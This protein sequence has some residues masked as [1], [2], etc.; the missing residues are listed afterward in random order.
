[1]GSS[2]IRIIKII[3]TTGP[4]GLTGS[5]G[6][7]GATGTGSGKTGPTGATAVYIQSISY[8]N[9]DNPIL[10]ASDGTRYTIS[11]L[12]GPTGTTGNVI[13]VTLGNKYDIL[14]S[15][16]GGTLN[17]YGLSFT[18]VLSSS[19]SNGTIVVTPTDQSAD[20]TISGD[21][22]TS[23]LIYAKNT[24]EISSTRIDALFNELSF[25]S[26]GVSHTSTFLDSS[27]NVGQ[28]PSIPQ[29]N[30]SAY[31]NGY[32]QVS[33]YISGIDPERGIYIDATKASI[34]T[35]ETP[36]GIAGFSLNNAIYETG[37]IVSITLFISGSELWS[38]PSN[39]YFEDKPESTYF[40]C[41]INIMNM[42]SNNKGASW[43]ATVS[44]RGY[45]VTG[46][47]DYDML[48]SCCYNDDEGNFECD[49]Y[50]T[51]G[52]CNR[53][54]GTF[55]PATTCAESCGITL[56]S[57]CCSE[58]R[59]VE[60]ISEDECELFGG[61]F[62]VSNILSCD[63]SLGGNNMQRLCYDKCQDPVVCCK[64]GVCLGEMT[65]PICEEI[66]GGRAVQ[67]TCE[68]V[69]C[70]KEIPFYGACCKTNSCREDYI[71]N[72]KIENDEVFMGHGTQ[73]VNSTTC[74]QAEQPYEGICCYYYGGCI[75]TDRLTCESSG[76]SFHEGQTDCQI[77]RWCIEG[78]P[79]C[80][81][82]PPCPDGSDNSV[83]PCNNTCPDG[84][85]IRPSWPPCP[86][87]P[88]YECVLPIWSLERVC[89]QCPDGAACSL[90]ECPENC[91][92]DIIVTP[93]GGV[94]P[95][96]TIPPGGGFGGGG[97]PPPGG[98]GQPPG[99]GG[100]PPSQCPTTC[101]GCICPK[102]PINGWMFDG[103]PVPIIDPT[104]S[105]TEC[106]CMI[107]RR[108]PKVDEIMGQSECLTPEELGWQNLDND[109]YGSPPDKIRACCYGLP[110]QGPL[111][112]AVRCNPRAC[113]CNAA[114]REQLGLPNEWDGIACC[115]KAPCDGEASSPC[116][117]C[118]PILRV[119]A[120]PSQPGSTTNVCVY[121][122]LCKPKAQDPNKTNEEEI[123]AGI[124]PCASTPSG[125]LCIQE[126]SAC[127]DPEPILGIDCR[128]GPSGVNTC[129]YNEFDWGSSTLVPDFSWLIDPNTGICN[130]YWCGSY[131]SPCF[132]S[133]YLPCSGES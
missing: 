81:V 104:T 48:G 115:D 16:V 38:F 32:S 37:D 26:P 61:K 87:P 52:F 31:I 63:T 60:N 11:G 17:L 65:K 39:V 13:G 64:N 35:I 46:C 9:N 90:S 84:S 47:D 42:T 2:A 79:R 85:P 130:L 44:D 102:F 25:A 40:G 132:D 50:R 88:S 124:C 69:D 86:G 98:G 54:N 18:G 4:T 101:E 127:G 129:E 66:F 8:D 118:I 82:Q 72:C 111:S 126:A 119:K 45:G 70:C 108:D 74:C 133:T 58:G 89:V 122:L 116:T 67:G 99:G 36:I 105:Q 75:G 27:F 93:P 49:D 33:P 109:E 34:F 15:I 78:D 10:I 97:D 68:T 28:I 12:T 96:I 24:S 55:R 125:C 23:K 113:Y 14:K 83:P 117:K 6:P 43:F 59:C 95:P 56:N 92:T 51:K 94:S 107:T 19:I 62:Y 103:E 131:P 100:Q 29:E 21:S 30:L 41:G 5:I 76:G 77:C 114:R 73:C 7:S 110:D 3:G 120:E 106:W 123:A 20:I 71:Y 91:G 121:N 128:W 22:L 53:V 1:M 57:F 80:T 112:G